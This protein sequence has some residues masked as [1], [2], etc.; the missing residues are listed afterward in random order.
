MQI[1]GAIHPTDAG[2]DFTREKWCKVVARRPEFHKRAPFK[3]PNPFNRGELVMSPEYDD[4]AEVIVD[5]QAV[6]SVYWSMNDKPLVNVA[7]EKSAMPLVA[8]WAKEMGGTF[9]EENR[10]TG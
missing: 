5:G 4:S 9:R 1:T 3:V 8:E 6:G 10:N 7:V 2:H